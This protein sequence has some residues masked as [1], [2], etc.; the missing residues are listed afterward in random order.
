MLPRINL[1][2]ES[3]AGELLSNVGWTVARA[4]LSRSRYNSIPMSW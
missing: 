2:L 1:G 3:G 4:I